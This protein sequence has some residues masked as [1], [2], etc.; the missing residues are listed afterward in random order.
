MNRTS[1]ARR[2]PAELLIQRA[3]AFPTDA[4]FLP[5]GQDVVP[6]SGWLIAGAADNHDIGDMNGALSLNNAA[7]D[8]LGR[9]SASVPLQETDPF[10]DNSVL[11]AKTRR[12]RPIL[13]RSF[14]AITFT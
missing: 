2:T 9:I 14:P 4:N 5:V 6:N 7:F 1:L 10:D 12:T 11:V 13:L 8:L 3:T